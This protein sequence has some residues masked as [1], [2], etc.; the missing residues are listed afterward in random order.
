MTNRT[1]EISTLLEDAGA[2]LEPA[3]IALVPDDGTWTV[4]FDDESVVAIV[5]AEA[6]DE[7]V[8]IVG[9]G[10]VPADAAAQ[11]HEWLLRASYLWQETGGVQAAIDDRGEAVLI[12]RRARSGLDAGRLA[13]L[14]A[15]LRAQRTAWRALM[16]SPENEA[17]SISLPTGIRV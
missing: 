4:G 1:E 17:T 7:L 8:F 13:G 6:L 9:L 10:T 3:V 14:L 5:A 15:N 12:Y 2:L 16:Q 11:V